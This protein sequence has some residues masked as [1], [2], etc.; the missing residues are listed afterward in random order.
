MSQQTQWK[1]RIV[2]ENHAFKGIG[3][4]AVFSLSCQYD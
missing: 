4:R 3:G 2:N 1:A